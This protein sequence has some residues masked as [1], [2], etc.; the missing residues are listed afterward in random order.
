M[1]D[2]KSSLPYDEVSVQSTKTRVLQFQQ[3]VT[4]SERRLTN[5]E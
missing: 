4:F 2:L 1:P 3:F 5:L